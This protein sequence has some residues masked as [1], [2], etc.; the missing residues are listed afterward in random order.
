MPTPDPGG[1]RPGSAIDDRAA[2]RATRALAPA[3]I[4]GR[5][6]H[7]ACYQSSAPWSDG[8]EGYEV[9]TTVIID[10]PTGLMTVLALKSRA[11][12]RCGVSGESL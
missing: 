1:G 11:Q 12:L 7:A 10:L 5:S 3:A 2:L 9:L 6:V 4:S 8:F